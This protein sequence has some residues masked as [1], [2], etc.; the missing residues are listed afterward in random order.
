MIDVHFSFSTFPFLVEIL[1][2]PD[3][4]F[5]LGNRLEVSHDFTGCLFDEGNLGTLLAKF[6]GHGY[7]FFPLTTTA[8]G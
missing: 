2:N 7:Y 8:P 5:R 3:R 4:P 6:I 1:S